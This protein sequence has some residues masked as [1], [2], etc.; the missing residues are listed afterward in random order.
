MTQDFDEKNLG[1]LDDPLKG[2]DELRDVL[3]PATGRLYGE[4]GILGMKIEEAA[5]SAEWWWEKTGRQSMPDYGKPYDYLNAY[6]TRSG[7]LLGLPWSSLNRGE[8]ISVVKQWHAHIGIPLHGMG[9]NKSQ[10][11]EFQNVIK[12]IERE[13]RI[14]SFDLGKVFGNTEN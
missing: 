10:D 6:G 5:K 12:A 2:W 13:K 3:D 9:F 7:V 14:R 11:K 8:K 1:V 4:H